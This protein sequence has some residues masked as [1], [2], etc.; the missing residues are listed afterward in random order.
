ML[1]MLWVRS[2][3]KGRRRHRARLRLLKVRCERRMWWVMSGSGA[4]SQALGE[5]GSRHCARD[6]YRCSPCHRVRSGYGYRNCGS[7]GVDRK[8]ARAGAG[9]RAQGHEAPCRCRCRL[10]SAGA[11]NLA[12]AAAATANA[13]ATA[14]VV[15]HY[16]I[17]GSGEGWCQVNDHG[18][19]PR[20]WPEA[21][22]GQ[23]TGT[24][25]RIKSGHRRVPATRDA[26]ISTTARG[27]VAAAVAATA[28]PSATIP[29]AA[30]PSA[31]AAA[32]AFASSS[33]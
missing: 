12:T 32:D 13:Y 31:A 22:H 28:V 24:H 16:A 29:T 23:A 4:C 27:T 14:I 26:A 21:Y 1:R 25:E 33:A 17:P 6:A 10:T 9:K 19:A 11:G 20:A 8:A 5:H 18:V 7:V 2:E 15:R 3:A 30:A